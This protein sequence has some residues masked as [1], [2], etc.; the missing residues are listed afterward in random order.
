MDRFYDAP[1]I[2]NT[3]FSEKKGKFGLVGANAYENTGR[4]QVKL[5]ATTPEKFPI[6]CVEATPA[7]EK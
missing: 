2:G 7:L 6:F 1:V 5:R 4:A 3:S